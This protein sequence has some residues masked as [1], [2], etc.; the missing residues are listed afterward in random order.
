VLNDWHVR[1]ARI[2]LALRSIAHGTEGRNGEED[3]GRALTIALSESS[4]ITDDLAVRWTEN[5][6]H[7]TG[8]DEEACE[9]VVRL[10]PP[11]RGESWSREMLEYRGVEFSDPNDDPLWSSADPERYVLGSQ[12]SEI[13]ELR[14]SLGFPGD[15]G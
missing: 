11:G 6:P 10:D 7:E 15:R 2:S 9:L 14:T 1:E 3:D 12:T 5:R 4:A 13:E 8:D